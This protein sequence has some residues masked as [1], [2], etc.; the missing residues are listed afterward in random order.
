M[1]LPST[2][3]NPVS[4]AGMVIAST[5]AVL[6]LILLLL[7]GLGAI[8]NP[9]IGLLLFVTIPV[10]FVVALL[11]IPLGAWRSSRRRRRFPE[12][13]EWPLIDLRNPQHRLVAVIVLMLTL[14]NILIVSMAAY[15]GVHY[16]DSSEFCGEVCHTT[17]E[18]QYVASKGW[19]HARVECAQC[20]VGPGASA[21]VQAKLAGTRQLYHVITNQIPK[22]IPSPSQLIRPAGDTCERCHWPEKFH[23]DQPRVIREFSND[24]QNTESTT[25]LTMHVGGG[26]VSAGAG[27]GI[28]WHMNIDNVVEFVA[29]APETIPYVRVTDRQGRVR[30]FVAKGATAGQYASAPKQRMDCMDCHNRPAHTMYFT[31]ERAVDAAIAQGRIPRTLPFARREAVAAVKADYASRD[32]A[33]SAI[34]RRLRGFYSSHT[35]ADPRQITQTIAG[36]QQVWSENVFPLM[37]VKWGTYPNNVGH[38]DSAGCFRCHDDEK[39]AADG[40][41]IKQD[42]ELCHTAPE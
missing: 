30:E 28:H 4:L 2:V 32:A 22:P 19:P 21:L 9:Y 20:H 18:P 6:F 5:M 27:T 15:G 31:P 16:M 36:V 40:T 25:T 29:T 34:D 42:C 24:E 7:E 10:L 8:S 41:V 12:Q 26:R 33:L 37:N 35:A 38:V 17:M 23:G 11:L 14:V 39:Q 1:R 3:A 13:S